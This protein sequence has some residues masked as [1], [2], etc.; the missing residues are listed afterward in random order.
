MDYDD[1][2]GLLRKD[3]TATQ[4]GETSRLSVPPPPARFVQAPMSASL[5]LADLGGCNVLLFVASGAVGKTTLAKKIA[6]D[7]SA[8]LW[9]LAT[10]KLGDNSFKGTLVSA[11]GNSYPSVVDSLANGTGCL[12]IDGLDE[13]EAGSGWSSLESFLKQLSSMVAVSPRPSVLLFSRVPT[14]ELVEL[15]L[16]EAGIRTGRI[17][18][19]FFDRNASVDFISQVLDD[20]GSNNHRTQPAAYADLLDYIFFETARSITP[21]TDIN[22]IWSDSQLRAFLGYAPVLE[23]IAALVAATRNFAER[24]RIGHDNPAGS[25]IGRI[26][27]SLLSRESQKLTEA[28]RSGGR[29]SISSESD[30]YGPEEQRKLVVRHLY[31]GGADSVAVPSGLGSSDESAYRDARRDFLPNHPFLHNGRFSGPAFRDYVLAYMLLGDTESETQARKIIES[32]AF[33]LTKLFLDFYLG[34]A[35]E[36]VEGSALFPSSLEH[37]GYLWEAD[38]AALRKGDCAVQEVLSVAGGTV[39]WTSRRTSTVVEFERGNSLVRLPF[40][41]ENSE[42]DVDGGLVLGCR[43]RPFRVTDSSIEADRLTIESNQLEVVCNRDRGGVRLASNESIRASLSGPPTLYD[44]GGPILFEWPGAS[45]WPFNGV[46]PI[47][48]DAND[49]TDQILQILYRFVSVFRADGYQRE[50][51]KLADL[52]RNRKASTPFAKQVVQALENLGFFT[53]KG[54]FFEVDPTDLANYGMTWSNIQQRIYP[55]EV[56]AFAALILEN[57]QQTANGLSSK[58]GS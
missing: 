56:R 43:N 4:V 24:P 12:V 7:V 57:I 58:G 48:E 9:D 50:Y 51:R 41:V 37:L 23:A 3:L 25:V 6:S 11:Y 21:G 16:E 10:T 27:E 29:I 22:N 13:A 26:M 40:S 30:L 45:A 18:I 35:R 44:N 17:D 36:V 5:S 15:A 46:E 49:Q 31:L 28:L 47:V 32:D 14:A 55:P 2:K 39:K 38:S 54:D 20:Q 53:V 34:F 8:P 42:V 1:V 33:R 52:I 19:Q